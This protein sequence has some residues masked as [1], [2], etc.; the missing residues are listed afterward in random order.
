MEL[1]DA[2]AAALARTKGVHVGLLVLLVLLAVWSGDV[3]T[4]LLLPPFAF[5]IGGVVETVVAG[6]TAVETGQGIGKVVGAWMLGQVGFWL[7]FSVA[8]EII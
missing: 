1:D 6:A 3:W 2:E 7:L 8:V 4:V 5:L